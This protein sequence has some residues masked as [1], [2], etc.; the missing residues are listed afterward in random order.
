MR[1]TMGIYSRLIRVLGSSGVV[2]LVS[3]GVAVGVSGVVSVA[4]GVLVGVGVCVSV[5]ALVGVQVGGS[6]GTGRNWVRLL[7][8]SLLSTIRFVVSTLA[9][10]WPLTLVAI[11]TV[12]AAL[13]PKPLAMSFCW[14][15]TVTKK[16]AAA[17]SPLL[18][19]VTRTPRVVEV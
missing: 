3:V 13:T 6:V 9:V 18:K 12:A 11:H 15:L 4:I 2:V 10:A 17:L 16:G 8:F 7:L 1:S 5:G 14:P 19:T